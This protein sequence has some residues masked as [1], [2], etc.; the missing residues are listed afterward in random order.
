MVSA[1]II[2]H[3]LTEGLRCRVGNLTENQKEFLIFIPNFN[4]LVENGGAAM[5]LNNQEI[6]RKLREQANALEDNGGMLYRVRAFR[7][8]AEVVLAL[9]EEVSNIVAKSGQQSLEQFPGI[10]KSLAKT[11]VGY[12]LSRDE[13]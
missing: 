10:G 12:V 11:I 13:K 7:Q 8:A 1:R 4:S 6:S 3:A 5:L 9:E 2:R